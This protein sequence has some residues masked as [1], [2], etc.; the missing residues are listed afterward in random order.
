MSEVNLQLSHIPSLR[1]LA[2]LLVLSLRQ[3][4]R[5]WRLIVLGVLFL[6]PAALVVMIVLTSPYPPKVDELDTW[7][8]YTLLANA[9]APLSALLCAA[10]VVRDE[11]EEQTLTYLLLRPLPRSAL[12]A[13]KL[14]A[15]MIVSTL[16]TIFFAALTLVVIDRLAG[17]SGGALPVDKALH[18][19]M[20]FS[21]TQ[22]A[23]CGL[24]GLLGLLMRRSLVIGVAYIILFEG[25]LA[26]FN[27]LA[28]KLTVMYYFRVLVR[29]WLN[30]ADMDWKIDLATAPSA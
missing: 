18:A 9:L 19:A 30:P 29:R 10:G 2:A 13:I 8:A 4:I 15:G 24:F 25:A 3:Q 6:L 26:A 17:K 7:I 22:A 16:L 23:Y 11:V 14:L 20:I 12:Y 28:R 21:V 1:A 5:G 27:T